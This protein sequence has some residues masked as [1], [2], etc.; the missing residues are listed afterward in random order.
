MDSTLDRD[1]IPNNQDVMLIK[2]KDGSTEDYVMISRGK[3]Y[4]FTCQDSSLIFDLLRAPGFSDSEITFAETY[5]I[6]SDFAIGLKVDRQ[7]T[8]DCQA[9]T[10]KT[11]F[12]V[13]LDNEYKFFFS[14]SN[15]SFENTR[16]FMIGCQA[17]SDA[18]G[19]DSQSAFELSNL[20][21]EPLGDLSVSPEDAIDC[22]NGVA[23]GAT[24]DWI[25][26]TDLVLEVSPNE[27]IGPYTYEAQSPDGSWANLVISKREGVCDWIEAQALQSGILIKGQVPSTFFN[28]SCEIAIS[29]D[30]PVDSTERNLR[31]F[32]D[33]AG[34][35]QIAGGTW[36]PDN[37]SCQMPPIQWQAFDARPLRPGI[38]M[39]PYRLLAYLQTNSDIDM[40]Y[41]IIETN[42]DWLGLSIDNII[43]TPPSDSFGVECRLV[44][45][46]EARDFDLVAPSSHAIEFKVLSAS[47]SCLDKGLVWEE[48][49]QQCLAFKQDLRISADGELRFASL[50]PDGNWV[51]GAGGSILSVWDARNGH[52]VWSTQGHADT[53]N[54][55]KFSPDSSKVVTASE[56][57]S[58]K[59]W[60]AQ[61]GSEL[62]SFPAFNIRAEF[63]MFSPDGTMIAA[64]GTIQGQSA[65]NDRDAA[66]EVWNIL[67]K[68]VLYRFFDDY[69]YLHIDFSSDPRYLAVGGNSL[70]I[71]DLY[72]S[73]V[74]LK[75]PDSSDRFR[76]ISFSNSGASAAS[77]EGNSIHLHSLNSDDD[78]LILSGHV[79]RV[80]TL[81]Y[82]WDDRYLLSSSAFDQTAR[83][84]N[85]KTGKEVEIIGFQQK[86]RSAFFTPDGRHII[87][88]NGHDITITK[89]FPE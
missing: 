37:H 59:V 44:V 45:T 3:G 22:K 56:D 11:L 32:A 38:P 65:I 57:G 19:F 14:D 35:C 20:L 30:S 28:D 85:A 73:S 25:Q 63:A 46:A 66:I 50:S 13:F 61:S 26:G 80:R 68:T 78:T 42:C 86:V 83:V 16:L 27:A 9:T 39:E 60:H 29:V 64:S 33:Y 75:F 8:I 54:S 24:S 53:I 69:E 34:D 51:A 48:G 49:G 7:P 4:K 6:D 76:Y 71:W 10:Q 15:P 21:V 5:R 87:T 40:T 84:W 55:A 12:R 18:M 70:P 41:E 58:V 88:A 17:L 72:S 2:I 89:I 67:G 74:Q 36:D 23:V 62:M 31:F 1:A 81:D 82:S 79:G 43:G 77:I 52:L 47:A